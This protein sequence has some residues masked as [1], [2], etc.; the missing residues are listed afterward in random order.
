MSPSESWQSYYQ[1]HRGEGLA[2]NKRL[3]IAIPACNPALMFTD[4]HLAIDDGWTSC[5]N[6]TIPDLVA[7]MS[8][9]QLI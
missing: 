3:A 5:A 8:I 1:V 6:L 9:L 7:G 2:C 4:A